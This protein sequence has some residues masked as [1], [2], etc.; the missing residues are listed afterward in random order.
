MGLV[1][2]A[3]QR[4]PERTVAIKVIAPELAAD[5]AFRARF[6]QESA[7]AAEIEHPNVIPVYEVGDDDG[8]LFISMRFVQGVDLGRLLKGTG[9]LDIRRASHA[10]GGLAVANPKTGRGNCFTTSNVTT[11]SDAYRCTSGNNIYDPCFFVNQTQV[12]CPSDGPWAATGLLLNVH[13]L[14]ST[15]SV[16]D[17][18][19]H[20][21]PWA[22][23]LA[24]GTRCLAVSGATNEIA[25]Q[26]LGYFCKGGIGLY[27]NVQRSAPG[28]TIFVGSPHSTTLAMKPIGVAWF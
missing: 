20:G 28:W 13:S 2:R 23:Q 26:R 18:G 8:L 11:R 4:R 22:I 1:Y 21:Q 19:T 14:P 12:L 15:G 25:G 24:D 27:G 6:E 10:S 17:Q 5:P 9:P 7:T 16:S 3:R